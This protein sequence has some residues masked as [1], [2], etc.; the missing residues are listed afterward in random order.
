MANEVKDLKSQLDRMAIDSRRDQKDVSRALERRGGHAA[1]SQDRKRSSATRSSTAR[2]A[3]PEWLNSTEPQIASDI[4][5]LGQRMQQA[6]S[7]AQNGNGQRQQAQAADKTRDS[8]RGLE[9]MDERMR[10]RAEQGGAAGQRGRSGSSSTAGTVR[11]AGPRSTAAGRSSGQGQ[12]QGQQGQQG[13]GPGAGTARAAG[14]GPGPR[15]TGPAGPRASAGATGTAG[16][17]Q[18]GQQG[19]QGQGQGKGQQGQQGQGQGQQGQ[20]GQGG[21]GQG[22]GQQQ[23]NGSGQGNG[24]PGSQQMNGGMGGPLN[25]NG[26]PGGGVPNGRLSPDDAQQFSREAQQRLADAQALRTDLQRQGLATKE[27]DQAIDNLRQLTNAQHARRSRASRRTCA[28]RPSKASKISNSAFA[29]S[30]ASPIRRAC[31]SSGRA[32]FPRRT[33]RTSRSTTGRSARG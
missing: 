21:Q 2:T 17:G 8:V 32:T 27:L 18:Q 6:Q 5:D 30:S 23:A 33:S 24:K 19:Q 4:A 3:P 26:V 10:Q 15:P 9:S 22:R 25:P 11:T 29:G 14:S 13:P 20:Q 7:A 31:C 12:A 16:P 1:R 28:R